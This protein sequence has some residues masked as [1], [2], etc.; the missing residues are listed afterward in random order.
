[1][2]PSISAIRIL[3]LLI[4]LAGY[5]LFTES[6]WAQA[7]DKIGWSIT[8]Y[9]WASN[10]KVDL[11]FRDTGIGGDTI[12]FSD[13]LDVLDT[14]FMLHVEG[15]KGKWS[16][17]GDLTYLETSDTDERPVLTIDTK[18]KQAEYKD[19]DLTTDFTY[20]GPMAGFNFRF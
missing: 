4:S 8:P 11:K 19:C 7:D 16:M 18:S 15:G 6:A 10:T 9:L 1:M 13:L 17:F 5:T 20:Y 3:V 12:T 2:Y 14:A